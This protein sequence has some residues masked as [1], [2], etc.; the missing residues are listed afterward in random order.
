RLLARSWITGLTATRTC[1]QS[2]AELGEVVTVRLVI[3]NDNWLPVP[4]VLIED[5]L[6]RRAVDP[7]FPGLKVQGRRLRIAMI[8]PRGELTMSYQLECVRRGYYQLGPAVLE[9]GDLFGL[10][11]RFRV[12]AG[13]SFLLVYPRVVAL[14]GYE[15]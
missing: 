1:K 14:T 2:T 4:W 12:A 6:P 11:R 13:P 10:H 3:R 15:I 5:M 7:R 8:R 9:T